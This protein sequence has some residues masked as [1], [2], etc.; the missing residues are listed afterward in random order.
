MDLNAYR[1]LRVVKNAFSYLKKLTSGRRLQRRLAGL[2]QNPHGGVELLESRAMLTPA[3]V[4]TPVV[5]SGT[6]NDAATG[7]RRYR[8]S[9][10]VATSQ[11]GA[12]GTMPCG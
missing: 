11:P 9:H 10:N 1:N 7:R 3:A 2:L 8:A 6:T 4:V 12:L 5:I